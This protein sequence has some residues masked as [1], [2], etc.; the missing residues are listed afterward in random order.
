VLTAL[1]GAAAALWLLVLLLP[2]RA[3]STRERLEPES[4]TAT[5]PSGIGVLIPARNEAATIAGTLRA[6]AGQPGV[7]RIV[8]IDDQSEDQTAARAA[9]ITG[10]EVVR[11][12][13][14]PAG[15]SGKLWA[16]QQ[17]LERLDT[18]R[19]LLLDADIALAPGM[20]AALHD[21]LEG[22][23]LDQVSI[24]ASLPA[25]SLP[26]RLMLPA[27]VYFF[28]QLYPFAWVNRADRPFAAAA[29]GCV[30]VR[31]CVLE[32]AGAFADWKDTLIDDCALAA[33]VR[34]A[35]GRLWIGL[36]HGVVSRRRHP[37]FASVLETVRRTAYTQLQHSPVWLSVV[38]LAML[39]LFALPPLALAVGAA[40]AS[41]ALIAV[42]GLGW[43]L[44]A[45]GYWPQVRFAGLSPGWALSL[46]AAGMLFL[47][48]T[49]ESAWRHHFGSGAGWKGRR[50]A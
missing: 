34:A 15:W 43:G 14:T 23:R 41:P 32:R 42:A 4:G 3:W 50:Y 27:F 10:V 48:A 24:M 8:V 30:L 20:V 46:P 16:Q 2:W 22:E 29:G 19:I 25:E 40:T 47:R 12:V 7:E 11:G 35:G 21:K 38:T 45:A 44:M 17:G 28:K 9:E 26:E 39:L 36:S 31:R 13:P 5:A 49:L 37:D 6:V 18:P 1:A 33:R